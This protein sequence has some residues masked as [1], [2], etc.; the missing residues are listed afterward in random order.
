MGTSRNALCPCGSGKKYKKCCL[1]QDEKAAAEA[2]RRNAEEKER[3]L[4][5]EVA[6]HDEFM[7]Y[8]IELEELSNRANDLT[9]SAQ[10]AETE[11]CC[12][13]LLERFPE[14]ID[15]HHRSYECCKAKGDLVGAKVH[16]EATLMMVESRD[17]FDPR[18]AA[19]L[20]KDIARF[21]ASIQEELSSK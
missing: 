11:A 3:R 4:L 18:F 17:G 19:E 9:R 1:A 2:H 20:K 14:E 6:E 21:E 13:E 12:R 7:K 10:W 8:A 16:A 5:A 15:G